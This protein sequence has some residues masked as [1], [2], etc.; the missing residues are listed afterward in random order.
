MTTAKFRTP[1]EQLFAN[2]PNKVDVT[3]INIDQ[4]ITTVAYFFDLPKSL[5]MK[6]CRQ[7]ELVL[8]RNVCYFILHIH[9]KLRA[10]QIAPLFKRD[11][12]T[13]LHGI[14]TFAN[15]VDVVP[16]YMEKYEAVLSKIDAYQ[17]L[18]INK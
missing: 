7:R 15:D 16:Y 9:F 6:K 10:S 3:K 8:A 12:T 14:N 5:I 1:R 4:L 17:H 2:K 18:Y 11:R 13:I